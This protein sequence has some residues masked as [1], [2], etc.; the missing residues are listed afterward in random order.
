MDEVDR[1][2]IQDTRCEPMVLH[3]QPTAKVKKSITRAQF[4]D[5]YNPNMTNCFIWMLELEHSEKRLEQAP[6]IYEEYS[7]IS[8]STQD[9]NT[10]E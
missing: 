6:V 4:E 2:K 1:D 9:L 8:L 10:V 3:F 7:K 5:I